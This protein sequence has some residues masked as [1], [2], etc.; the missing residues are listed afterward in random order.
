MLFLAVFFELILG[1][2]QVGRIIIPI[3]MV[4]TGAYAVAVTVFR[5]RT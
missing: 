5:K 3:V 4:V 2:S 1:I